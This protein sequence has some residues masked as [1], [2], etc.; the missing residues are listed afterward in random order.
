MN[1]DNILQHITE[2]EIFL[3]FLNLSEFPKTNISS[4]FSDDS[5]PS[6]KLYK[7]NS[8][9]CNST[10][11]QGDCWQLVA[12]LHELDC[13]TEFLKVTD[14][15]CKEFGLNGYAPT[16]TVPKIKKAPKVVKEVNPLENHFKYTTK[17]YE[18]THLKYWSQKNW[19]VT[20]K[21]L[22]K[23]NVKTL[24]KFEY[25][26]AKKEEIT[27]LKMYR[28]VIGFA[29]CFSESVAE[30]Y[31]PK[32]EKSNKFFLNKTTQKDI[33]G[34]SQLANNLEYLIVS[35]GKKD[36]LILN[37]N[38]FPAVTFRSENHYITKEQNKALLKKAKQIFICYDNDIAG[39]NKA[40]QF[41]ELYGF[42]PIPLPSKINDIADYFIENTKINFQEIINNVLNFQTPVKV[43]EKK[44]NNEAHTIFHVVENYLTE[45][46]QF[47]FNTILLDIEYKPI[48]AKEW[49]I[50]NED[51]L[52][53]E[54]QKKQI[55]I[56]MSKLISI[57]KSDFVPHYNPITEYF[58]GL[59]VWNGKTDHIKKLCSFV[60][61]PTPDEFEYN[62]KKWMARC[63][64][65]MCVKGY[66]NKQAFIITDKGNGQNIGKSH[67]TKWLTI[68]TLP[69]SRSFEDSKKDNLTKLATNTFIILDELDGISKKDINA[70]KALFSY[71]EIRIR[72]PYARREETVQRIANFIGSTNEESFLVDPTGSVRWLVF[73]VTSI[74]WAYS[75]VLNVN[76]LWSQAYALAKDIN[77]DESFTSQDVTNNEKR[78][79]A[80]QV[81]TP[82]AELILKLFARPEEQPKKE[83]VFMTSTEIMVYIKSNSSLRVS[84]VGVG[85]ALKQLKFPRI[86]SRGVYGYWM[87]YDNKSNVFGSTQ[88]L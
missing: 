84:S 70:L 40:K 19:N 28:N 10:G 54:L 29:Y 71:D 13:K 49:L 26:N 2:Q 80:Y 60:K 11:K 16:S 76:N 61:T 50:C 39:I 32:Q 47:R 56:Q 62:L 78:N 3:K 67:F 22:E 85:R 33:F 59:E 8:F 37:A 79:E 4:P 88:N 18:E 27:K 87:V 34:Y 20:Q 12:Y 43:K 75:S 41:Q 52:F 55:N 44:N 81:L 65:C 63:V 73:H 72:L 42:T 7:N 35:A 24:D 46:Y 6:F 82:E 68:P 9:K 64:K 69:V 45:R 66:F 38:G 31:I 86:K 48:K 15:I 5:K 53:I 57:L 1:K 14:I 83:K 36:C 23:Y 21:D 74:D 77:F 25:Y 17:D 51:S 58:K 30:L